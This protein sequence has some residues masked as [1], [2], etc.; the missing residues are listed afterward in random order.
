MSV[1]I[2]PDILPESP[3]TIELVDDQTVVFES[4]FSRRY[5][6]RNSYGDPRW[7][8]RRRYRGMRAQDRARLLTAL[9][10]ARGA[11]NIVY[12][13]PAQPIR[14]SFPAPELFLNSD[15]AQGITG[16]TGYISTLAASGGVLRSTSNG[17]AND[18]GLSQTVTGVLHAPYVIRAL[19]SSSVLGADSLI[20][21]ASNLSPVNSSYAL[22]SGYVKH[23]GVAFGTSLGAYPAWHNASSAGVARIDR[24]LNYSFVSAARCFL[25]DNRPN[26]LTYSDD[27]S[28]AAWNKSGLGITTP[29]D[30]AP[31]GTTTAD[32]ITEDT[33]TGQHLF[34]QSGTRP[35]VPS[36]CVAFGYFKLGVLTRNV[37]LLV[38]SGSGT[39]YGQCLFDLSAVTAGVPSL[40][41][42]ATN[43]RAFIQDAGNGWRFCAIVARLP[44]TTS[45]RIYAYMHNGVSTSYTGTTGALIGW[46]VGAAVSGVPTRGM[47]TVATAFSSG[48]AQTGSGIHVKGLPVSTNGLLLPGDWVEIN[49]QLKMVTA[50][51]DSDAAGL[52]Y[53]QF[54]P[55]LHRP[56]NDNDPIIVT[57]P[58]GKFLLRA[59][60]QW[61]NRFGQY[62]DMELTLDEVYE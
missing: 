21:E 13:S 45:L 48:E 47:Q 14:G 41:G 27:F 37:L 5:T 52:G 17:T 56:V 43:A 1:I 44:A 50:S 7:R 31:D 51:L 54:R 58:M 24:F 29:G 30:V 22:R 62:A 33:S 6:Q 11:F 25:V 34:F 53:L 39:D 42:A 32:R 28:N 60:A 18:F 35:N 61:D 57:K 55:K 26:A 12:V 49:G 3:E 38:D 23:S 59:G 16:W 10:E 19:I 40:V 20:C 36:D 9:G 8:L 4:Q 15:F 2:P 46:R